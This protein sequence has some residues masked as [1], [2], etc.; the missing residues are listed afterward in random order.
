[1]KKI[2]QQ[3]FSYLSPF[4]H[5]SRSVKSIYFS[6]IFLLLPQIVLLFIQHDMYAT[7]NIFSSTT[8]TLICQ[9]I[10]YYTEKST[11]KIPFKALLQGLLI[12]FF[13]PTNI[14]FFFVFMLSFLGFF[15][16]QVAFGKAGRWLHSLAIVLI[17]AYISYPELFSFPQQLAHPAQN[18]RQTESS[19]PKESI[20]ASDEKEEE[21]ATL[22]TTHAPSST[23]QSPQTSHANARGISSIAS[24]LNAY[25]LNN[26]GVHLPE[27][28]LSLFWDSSHD[29][30][31]LRYNLLT[32]IASIILLSLKVYDYTISL[33]FLLV[34]SLLVYC[35]G[36]V[37]TAG[38]FEGDILYSLLSGGVLFI[39]FFAL[40]EPHSFPKTF[41][42][43]LLSAIFIGVV[44]F[45]LAN[46]QASY[47]TISFA[48][49]LLNVISPFVE[50]I[51]KKTRIKH[52]LC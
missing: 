6:F 12:G 19:K 42:F 9:G 38:L 4:I 41:R 28:Y 15:L 36:K 30:P 35:F 45:L 44:S 49:L 29:I 50:E 2:K 14:G 11:F 24:F 39:T 5:T 10:V 23:L 3:E 7:L 1:M 34:Y 22:S 46:E 43:K 20:I 26:L 21:K 48:I 52:S 27:G 32:I 16:T 47:I 51:E 31:A 33:L 8:A 25:I 37:A 17:I 18:G 40:A 13:M